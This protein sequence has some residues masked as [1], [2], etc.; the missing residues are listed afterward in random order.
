[1]WVLDNIMYYNNNTEIDAFDYFGFKIK[2]NKLPN[3]V[4][5]YMKGFLGLGITFNNIITIYLSNTIEKN[6]LLN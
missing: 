4:K 2:N 3:Y 6:I 1:M 5:N